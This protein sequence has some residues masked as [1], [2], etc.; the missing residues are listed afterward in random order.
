[1]RLRRRPIAAAAV[2]GG[3]AHHA[4][5]SG[6]EAGAAAS[7]QPQEA[8]PAAAPAEAGLSADAMEQLKQ[9]GALHEQG[10]LTDE[11]FAEQK[12]KVLAG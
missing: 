4:A 7:Q 8:P 10:V 9:L 12:A 5:K 2:V 6:A 11:E 1:M 3:V